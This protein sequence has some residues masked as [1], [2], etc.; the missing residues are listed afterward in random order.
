MYPFP[1]DRL[2]EIAR[3]A[4]QIL[5]VELSAG[6]MLEDVQLAI[7]GRIPISFYGKLGGLVPLPEEIL[8]EIKKLA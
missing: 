3:S 6:Q 8:A 5:V 2:G 1:Y 7:C 4:K